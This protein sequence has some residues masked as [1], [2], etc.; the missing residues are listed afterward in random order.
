[1]KGYIASA[2][3]YEYTAEIHDDHWVMICTSCGNKCGSE[4]GPRS[5]IEEI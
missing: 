3:N 1:M 5:E 2:H 4:I